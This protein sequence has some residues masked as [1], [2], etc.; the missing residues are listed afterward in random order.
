M[1]NIIGTK[2]HNELCRFEWTPLA[3]LTFVPSIGHLPA[4]AVKDIVVTYSSE[5]PLQLKAAAA[6]LKAAQLKIAAGVA[7]SDWDNRAPAGGTAAPEP[8][9]EVANAKE[10]PP[11]SLPLKVS[12][13]LTGT[14]CCLAPGLF[15][16]QTALAF[17][18]SAI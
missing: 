1:V 17:D 11:V 16:A 10:A 18:N 13:A 14:N 4:G 7:A 6:S 2:H 9:L 12:F 15:H 8:K 5:K 3:P